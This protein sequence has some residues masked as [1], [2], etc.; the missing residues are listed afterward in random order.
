MPQNFTTAPLAKLSRQIS[1]IAPIKKMAIPIIKNGFTFIIF[2]Q[3]IF[4]M[5]S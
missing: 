4:M 2:F 1:I 3:F 5:Q